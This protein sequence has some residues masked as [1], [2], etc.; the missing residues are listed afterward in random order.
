MSKFYSFLFIC[1]LI[2]STSVKLESKKKKKQKICTKLSRPIRE[3]ADMK[4]AIATI[5][6]AINNKTLL[7]TVDEDL[8]DETEYL[9]QLYN[10]CNVSQND[11]NLLG[12]IINT[13]KDNQ[14]MKNLHVCARAKVRC[15][16]LY[17]ASGF[18]SNQPDTLPYA[19]LHIQH[20]RLVQISQA[21]AFHP[22]QVSQ[23]QYACILGNHKFHC[24]PSRLHDGN[25]HQDDSKQA[26]SQST[27]E[28]S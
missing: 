10:E 3:I 24:R 11:M 17:P 9:Y 20:Q 22:R 15:H 8:S 21:P 6:E 26:A 7:N 2:F 19:F 28:L 14:H 4:A 23:Q 25:K 18:E 27:P 12:K 16:I 13:L 5:Q 1:L